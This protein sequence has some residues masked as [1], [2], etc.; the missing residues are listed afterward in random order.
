[1]HTFEKETQINIQYLQRELCKIFTH[2]NV[3]TPPCCCCVLLGLLSQPAAATTVATK[4]NVDRML[5]TS[6]RARLLDVNRAMSDVLR[7]TDERRTQHHW[8]PPIS[9]YTVRRSQGSAYTKS[10]C[11]R[12]PLPLFQ[13]EKKAFFKTYPI[14]IACGQAYTV[15]VSWGA[16][17]RLYVCMHRIQGWARTRCT[18]VDE[19]SSVFL[20]WYNRKTILPSSNT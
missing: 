10:A 18:S 20:K 3:P 5:W 13:A 12:N 2:S 16:R 8:Q 19:T 15:T 9:A 4:T 7:F 14:R 11:G 6:T 1:M 17:S